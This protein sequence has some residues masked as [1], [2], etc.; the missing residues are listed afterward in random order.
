MSKVLR[1]YLTNNIGA[2]C[3]VINDI[4]L[5]EPEVGSEMFI[6]GTLLKYNG[7]NCFKALT[8]RLKDRGIWYMDDDSIQNKTIPY[9]KIQYEVFKVM[10]DKNDKIQ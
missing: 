2:K 3:I 8:G 1:H 4:T 10:Q 6:R 9:S 7:L 5:M